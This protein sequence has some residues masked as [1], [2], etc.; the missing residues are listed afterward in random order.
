[1]LLHLKHC[2]VLKLRDKNTFSD[3]RIQRTNLINLYSRIS[4]YVFGHTLSYPDY[5][6]MYL[7]TKR[8]RYN[9][10]IGSLF[11]YHYTMNTCN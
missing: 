8:I 6:F 10:D 4:N 1:M 7:T 11:I 5:N 3:N 9:P 2:H